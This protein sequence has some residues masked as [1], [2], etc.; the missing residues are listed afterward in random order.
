MIPY[1]SH[2]IATARH[3]DHIAAADQARRAHEA[4]NQVQARSAPG[5]QPLAWVRDTASA[6]AGRLVTV[7]KS[8]PR[9][10]SSH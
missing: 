8:A 10:V 7:V 6:L 1:S 9:A 5:R 3:H 4:H 2:Q